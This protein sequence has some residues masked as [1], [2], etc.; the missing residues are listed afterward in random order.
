MDQRH[1]NGRNRRN[2]ARLLS[3]KPR[4]ASSEFGQGPAYVNQPRHKF[5]ATTDRQWLRQPPQVL[6]L[7]VKPPG[8]LASQNSEVWQNAR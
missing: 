3:V 7:S 2:L 1:A 4:P 6:D 5:W 8:T